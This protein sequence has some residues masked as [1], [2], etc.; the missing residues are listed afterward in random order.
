[1][2]TTPSD[3]DYIN[4][5]ALE[6]F[7]RAFDY[8]VRGQARLATTAPHHV[9]PHNSGSED[10]KQSSVNAPAQLDLQDH[11]ISFW[12]WF[13]LTNAIIR[14]RDDIRLRKYN[15]EWIKNNIH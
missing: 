7:A 1:M 2:G 9:G 8:V 11:G 3:P 14:L 4:T 10:A 6:R 12:H 13:P 15:S 5:K